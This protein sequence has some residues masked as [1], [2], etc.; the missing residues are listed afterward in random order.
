MVF[1]GNYAE[2]KKKEKKSVPKGYI[3]MVQFT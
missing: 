1:P 2:P 3:L